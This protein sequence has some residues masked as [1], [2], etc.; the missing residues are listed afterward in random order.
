MPPQREAGRARWY[1]LLLLTA[2]Y[3]LNIADRFVISTL[4]EPIKADL[5]ISDYAVGFLTGASLA[6]F[7]VAAGLPLSA[8]ADRVNRR[9]LIAVALGAWS[10]MTVI[11][12]FTR[13]FWQLMIARVMV[14][15]GEAGGTPPSQSLISDYFPWRRRALA[16]SVYAVGAAIGSMLGSSMGYVSDRWGWRSAF[17][18][19]GVPGIVVAL[20]VRIT[21]KEPPRGR[22]DELAPAA[23][24]APF[25][26]MLR[27]AWGEPALRHA[28][29]GGALYS[30]WAFG[31]L[32]WL[33][34]LLVR[35]HHM[36]LGAAGGAVSLMHGLG[37]T[38][39][40]LGTAALMKK[41][42][43]LDARAVPLFLVGCCALGSI[44]AAGALLA[45]GNAAALGM[46]WIF[47]P[48]S[49]AP[50]G[51]CFAL[52]QNLVPPPMRS[53]IVGLFLLMTTVGNL[54]IAPQLIG[55]GSDLLGARY[56][57]DSL[58]VALLPLSLVGLWAAG[59][60][61]ACTLR[62]KAGLARAGNSPEQ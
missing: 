41:L 28:L 46:L 34:S 51:P 23:A 25:M 27:T 9:N 43:P 48:L 22:L 10:V 13:T 6:L 60:F 8:L 21:V 61:W 54:V 53:K 2:V 42:I 59:H 35:S 16:L 33:P 36:T 55:L 50:I 11:C 40:L 26:E 17:F 38:L 18:V 5:H 37:G 29:L 52:I 19:L 15:V 4:I 3:A 12:G 32:W 44:P 20:V 56:G 7:Y 14:G 31:L 24:A 62:I 1:V 30:T 39:V 49:Y 58:R 45:A 47:V 57:A